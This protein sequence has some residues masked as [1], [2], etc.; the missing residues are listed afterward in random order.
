MK[1]DVAIMNPPYAGKLH[2]KILEKVIPVAEKVVKIIKRTSVN[3][4]I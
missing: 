1:F 3:S 4:K 2:L